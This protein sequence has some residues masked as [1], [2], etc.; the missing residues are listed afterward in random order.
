MKIRIYSILAF[1]TLVISAC[2][3][4]YV[5]KPRG[6][7]KIELPRKKYQQFDKPGFPYTF[8]YPVYGQVVQDSLFFDQ[9]P[10]NPSGSI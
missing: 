5:P 4:D 10:E 7:F 3:S 9:K 2:N 8:E 6:Y 1:L